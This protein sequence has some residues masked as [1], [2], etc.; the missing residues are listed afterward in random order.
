MNILSMINND[1]VI[2]NK[3]NVCGQKQHLDIYKS[4]YHVSPDL[5]R[6]LKV[7]QKC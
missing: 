5:D 4:R 2:K 7:K 1:K 3:F 6:N